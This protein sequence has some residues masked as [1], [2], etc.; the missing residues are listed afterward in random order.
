M[1]P[2]PPSAAWLAR[3]FEVTAGTIERDLDGLRQAGVPIWAEAGRRGGYTLDR[4]QTLPPLALT[5]DEALALSVALRAVATSPFADH[6]RHAG[7]VW[8]ITGM[9][10]HTLPN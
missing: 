5:A 4:E 1:A 3:R 7:R 9:R 8:S 10:S 6:A 2:R